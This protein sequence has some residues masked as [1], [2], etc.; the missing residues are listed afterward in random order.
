MAPKTGFLPKVHRESH[1]ITP[2]KVGVQHTLEKGTTTKQ[3]NTMKN[4]LKKGTTT[5]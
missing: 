4:K 1:R 3:R 5:K 2:K